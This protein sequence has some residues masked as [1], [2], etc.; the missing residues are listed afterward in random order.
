VGRD[1]GQDDSR[2]NQLHEVFAGGEP[3][4]ISH[5]GLSILQPSPST[6]CPSLLTLLAPSVRSLPVVTATDT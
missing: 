3:D 4:L 5:S 2:T 1:G 6:T